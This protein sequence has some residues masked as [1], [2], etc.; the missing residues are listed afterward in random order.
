M[1][2]KLVKHVAW[3]VGYLT[4]FW[5]AFEMAYQSGNHPVWS[6]TWGAPVPH[7]YVVG[8][9]VVLVAYVWMTLSDWVNAYKVLRVMST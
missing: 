7:H 3:W 1:N 5:G 4:A 8:F 2:V 6:G 9:I